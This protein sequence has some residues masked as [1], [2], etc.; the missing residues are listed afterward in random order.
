MNII[1]DTCSDI[2]AHDEEAG[3]ESGVTAMLMW[4]SSDSGTYRRATAGGGNHGC[5]WHRLCMSLNGCD[6]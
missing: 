5:Q 2:D 4:R 3:G 6:K 1:E